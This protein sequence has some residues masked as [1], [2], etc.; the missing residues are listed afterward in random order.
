MLP[1]IVESLCVDPFQ[2]FCLPVIIDLSIFLF[3]EHCSLELLPSNVK[4]NLS[5]FLLYPLANTVTLATIHRKT[6]KL[7]PPTVMFFLMPDTGDGLLEPCYCPTPAPHLERKHIRQDFGTDTQ[8]QREGC[9]CEF[10]IPLLYGVR[11]SYCLRLKL[12]LKEGIFF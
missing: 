6:M 11:C 8:Q 5:S 3:Q 10:Q 7:L 4:Y 9:E 2:H 1:Y 12:D